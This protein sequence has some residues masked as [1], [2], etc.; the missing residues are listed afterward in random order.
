MKQKLVL[1]D[2]QDSDTLQCLSLLARKE[3]YFVVHY[4]PSRYKNVERM[5]EDLAKILDEDTTV[6]AYSFGTV[7]ISLL[8]MKL[9]NVYYIAPSRYYPQNV[10][11]TLAPIGMT[12]LKLP[13]GLTMSKRLAHDKDNL[14]SSKIPDPLNMRVLSTDH[15]ISRSALERLYRGI[16][17][18]LQIPLEPVLV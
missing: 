4:K 13:D 18:E 17:L 8:N 15:E 9:K 7:L 14:D 2:G 11:S 3:G 12:L 1:V 10:S 6:I 5:K 16:S